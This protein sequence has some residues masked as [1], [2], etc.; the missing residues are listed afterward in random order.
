MQ[1]IDFN[2]SNNEEQTEKVVYPTDKPRNLNELIFAL[3]ENAMTSPEGADKLTFKFLMRLLGPN[4]RCNYEPNCIGATVEKPGVVIL[5]TQRHVKFHREL[6]RQCNGVVLEY[7]TWR[8][9]ALPPQMFNGSSY[10][11]IDIIK[12]LHRYN[13]YE[14]L[15]GT[16]V[17][18]YWFRDCWKL[19]TVRNYDVGNLKW[20]GP[21]TYWEAFKEVAAGYPN[22]NLDKL[23]KDCSYTIGFRHSHFHPLAADP[24]KMWAI[25]EYNRV[26]V[27]VDSWEP[28]VSPI[29]L[30]PDIGLP[31]Q[32]QIKKPNG[33]SNGKYFKEMVLKNQVALGQFLASGNL[34]NRVKPH[35]GYI[36]RREDGGSVSNI[37]LE[38]SLLRQIKYHV[39]NVPD[40]KYR[41][42]S[43]HMKYII[44]RAFL[45]C[46]VKFEFLQLFPQYSNEYHNLDKLFTKLANTIIYSLRN[47][48]RIV[49][50]DSA[51]INSK[52]NNLASIMVQLIEKCCHVNVLD[53]NGLSIILDFII[54]KKY[55]EMYY[56]CLFENTKL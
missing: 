50:N 37:L 49:T 25:Q 51:D 41:D 14:V 46:A 35:Y 3:Q 1:T 43:N 32:T 24:P 26:G 55:L 52:I 15:D 34:D 48:T 18:L 5:S 10:K 19:A 53:S 20:V 40:V 23:N 33:S 29:R 11:H 42:Q 28:L 22:F 17:T 6:E 21:L 39:Y 13:I 31:V 38:S 44:L 2:N 12:S 56:T 27:D 9:L 47:R 8:I 36:L 54:D 30:S 4:I 7:P 16:T 45:N